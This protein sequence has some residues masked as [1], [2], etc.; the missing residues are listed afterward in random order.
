MFRSSSKDSRGMCH[1]S[2]NSP[3]CIWLLGIWVPSSCQYSDLSVRASSCVIKV[4]TPTAWLKITT[5]KRILLWSH[6]WRQYTRHTIKRV[7]WT[8]KQRTS[9][10]SI[11]FSTG[12]SRSGCRR[13]SRTA[14][15]FGWGRMRAS[16]SAFLFR[17][18][19]S[20]RGAI[21]KLKPRMP[22]FTH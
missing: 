9:P 10:Y 17:S 16:H 2:K 22:S 6:L 8:T 20:S 13:K 11:Q 19:S 5:W 18:S 3:T 1:S 14:W 12:T 21:G 15:S 4:T 7:S